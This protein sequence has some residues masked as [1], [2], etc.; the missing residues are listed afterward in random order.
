[1]NRR[2]SSGKTAY[3]TGLSVAILAG[4]ITLTRPEPRLVWNVTASVP[5][6]LYWARPGTAIRR[7]DLALV[8]VPDTVR[9]LAAARGYIPTG[10]SLIKPVA[11]VAGDV[12]CAVGTTISINGHLVAE[13]QTS[14]SHGRV[15]PWWQGCG[16]L[17]SSEFLVLAPSRDSFDSR[18]FGPVNGQDVIARLVPLWVR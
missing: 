9:S 4:A 6:G 2:N 18:Y 8:P 13:R 15:L 1:L 7:G 10:I 16:P 12:V 17:R 11:A 3:F 5:I 14:D